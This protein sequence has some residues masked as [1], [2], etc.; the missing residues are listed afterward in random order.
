MELL[1]TISVVFQATKLL[2]VLF[3]SLHTEEIKEDKGTVH[4]LILDSKKAYDCTIF[5]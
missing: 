5:S 3:A 4:Q 1:A 2:I